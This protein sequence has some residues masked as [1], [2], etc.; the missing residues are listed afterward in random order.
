MTNTEHHQ[1]ASCD[2][3][4]IDRTPGVLT[5]TDMCVSFYP[6]RL[7]FSDPMRWSA[8]VGVSV[9]QIAWIV[10]CLTTPRIGTIAR[11]RSRH[12]S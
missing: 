2:P 3:L 11:A 4:V 5:L 7:V 12:A 8:G 1:H 9:G 10:R 6:P